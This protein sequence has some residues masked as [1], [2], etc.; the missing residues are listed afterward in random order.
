MGALKPGCQ[1]PF[2]PDRDSTSCQVTRALPQE[3]TPGRFGT[4][5]ELDQVL[6]P[7]FELAAGAQPG[8]LGPKSLQA[9]DAPA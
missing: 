6:A 1:R 7:P 4:Y 9:L 3:A 5:P 8:Q 2:Q